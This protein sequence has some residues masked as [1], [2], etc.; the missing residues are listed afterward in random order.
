MSATPITQAEIARRVGV[1]RTM[2][3]FALNDRLHTRMSAETRNRILKMVNESG[4]RPHR[5]AQLLRKVKSAVIGIIKTP[6]YME[7]PVDRAFAM[8]N[9]I[10]RL[11]Y[12]PLNSDLLGEHGMRMACDAM[13]DERVEGV[14]YDG[15]VATTHRIQLQRLQD[16]GIPLLT[17]C[18]DRIPGV[19]Y[20]AQDIQGG[21]KE[22]TQHLLRIG[23]RKPILIIRDVMMI[24]DSYQDLTM[25]ARI[26]GYQEAISEA[27]LP[28]GEVFYQPNVEGV[29]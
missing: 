22:L 29:D 18:G 28:P 20:V 8:A 12:R 21:M 4:Y 10:H 27:G 25:Q 1:S 14:I 13:I 6:G 3:A 26:D 24:A 2:V 11:G 23:H 16:A 15:P 7:A 19:P 9:E 17:F 5:Q